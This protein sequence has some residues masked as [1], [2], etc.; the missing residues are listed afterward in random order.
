MNYLKINVKQNLQ[1]Q[2]TISTETEMKRIINKLKSNTRIKSATKKSKPK[3]NSK[4]E[5]A[6]IKNYNLDTKTS[7]FI[8]NF[9]KLLTGNPISGTVFAEQNRHKSHQNEALKN[10]DARQSKLA[11]IF[12]TEGKGGVIQIA[13]EPLFPLRTTIEYIFKEFSGQKV[14]ISKA[15]QNSKDKKSKYCPQSPIKSTKYEKENAYI[16]SQKYSNEISIE[17]KILKQTSLKEGNL[18]RHT[19]KMN[20]DLALSSTFQSLENMSNESK[21]CFKFNFK[22]NKNSKIIH[23]DVIL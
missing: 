10:M 11:E 12:C 14:M 19:G 17:G 6:S 7:E 23:L 21:E 18:K 13:G 9:L 5:E 1:F 15:I 8:S 20:S 2:V 3:Y 22:I 16:D 4:E